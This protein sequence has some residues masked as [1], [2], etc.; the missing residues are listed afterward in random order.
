MRSFLCLNEN[1]ILTLYAD[2]YTLCIW[3]RYGVNMKKLIDFKDKKLV[4]KI[5]DY[6]NEHCEGNF[7]MAVRQLTFNALGRIESL[8]SKGKK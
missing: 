2:G 5:Q 8:A 7:N 3:K 6:A 4:D 1:N